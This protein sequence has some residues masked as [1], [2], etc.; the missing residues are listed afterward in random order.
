[1]HAQA[2]TRPP[3]PRRRGAGR[4]SARRACARWMPVTVTGAKPPRCV[5]PSS[6]RCPTRTAP[7]TTV[8]ATTLPTPATSKLWSTCGPSECSGAGWQQDR[9]SLGSYSFRQPPPGSCTA[10]AVSVSIATLPVAACA[11]DAINSNARRSRGRSKL[12]VQ[13]RHL[14]T[15]TAHSRNSCSWQNR[16]PWQPATGPACAEQAPGRAWKCAGAAA[17]AP[18]AVTPGEPAQP[19][20]AGPCGAV[21][22]KQGAD[23]SQAAAAHGSSAPS[24]L[25]K[26]SQPPPAGAGRGRAKATSAHAL[27]GSPP[28]PPPPAW[29]APRSLPHEGEAGDASPL[30]EP[31]PDDEEDEEVGEHGDPG[32]LPP[33][34]ATAS[35]RASAPRPFGAGG[36]ARAPP[37]PTA[38]A[39][40]SIPLAQTERW[41]WGG[42][43]GPGPNLPG[44]SAAPA[45]LPPGWPAGGC[46]APAPGPWRPVPG[47]PGPS[48]PRVGRSANRNAC[49]SGSA[50][51]VTQDT[52]KSGTVGGGGAPGASPP[53]AGAAPGASD[54]GWGPAAPRATRAAPRLLSRRQSASCAA[55]GAR[56]RVGT[57]ARHALQKPSVH[58][59]CLSVRRS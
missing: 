57:Q 50:A 58:R 10:A 15:Q 27:A 6:R 54:P 13:H 25:S 34:A 31:R 14:Q 17:S 29:L 18:A 46:A 45:R 21:A 43:A 59:R 38:R 41:P 44:G 42:Q 40:A 19:A 36:G 11:S 52:A 4:P 26:P 22:A 53:S 16:E 35:A 51:P 49:S 33:A 5:G 28:P 24:L 48:A 32:R 20:A 1:M 3:Q 8:P 12:S 39:P 56:S 9:I 23:A 55:C 47:A 7:A 37:P 2:L 30:A